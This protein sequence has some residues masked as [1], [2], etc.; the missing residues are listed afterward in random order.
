[1]AKGP[2]L[3][4]P[5][6]CYFER[7]QS[8]RCSIVARHWP[9]TFQAAEFYHLI[10]SVR[11]VT[12]S[13]FEG[14]PL[15]TLGGQCRGQILAS[16]ARGVDA[17]LHR[18]AKVSDPVAGLCV[19]Q[20]RRGAHNAE[21]DWHRGEIRVE[22][23]SS[24]L[25]WGRTNSSWRLHFRNIKFGLFDE[26]QLAIFTPLEVW[27][28]RH[29]L[30]FGVSSA[31]KAT[32]ALGHAVIVYGPSGESNWMTAWQ[33]IIDKLDS[34]ASAC[35]KL[36]RLRLDDPLI[37]SALGLHMERTT[38]RLTTLAYAQT[39]L[40]SVGNSARGKC[41]EQIV[42]DIDQRVHPYVKFES[43]EK[44]TDFD[45]LRGGCRIECKSSMLHWNMSSKTWY[46]SFHGLKGLRQNNAVFDELL[47]VIY[48]P[49]GLFVYR[50]DLELGV[51]SNGQATSTRGH[52]V[53]I[54]GVCKEE[55]W[56]ISL[57]T[58]LGKLDSGCERVAF[59]S[60]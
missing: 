17:N 58:I 53:Y 12:H 15:A 9:R 43:M 29:D 45:W 27:V 59:V 2:S 23:K 60:W 10:D 8:R 47:L 1:M 26:L 19:N 4:Y 3:S 54:Y 24:Q 49:L 39:P 56:R 51:A 41:L 20:Y 5:A 16:V 48:S 32:S 25:I 38:A 30:K 34:N 57:R 33:A 50:H 52:R 7:F 18:N 21:Y 46:V 14:V 37:V 55:D 22:C 31:G 6:I 42:R 11:T 36:A 28:Y 13:T 35:E 40:I 44:Q